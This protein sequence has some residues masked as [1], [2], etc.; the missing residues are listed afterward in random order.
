MSQL[1]MK[2]IFDTPKPAN[3]TA[4]QPNGGPQQPMPPAENLY[5]LGDELA[6]VRDLLRAGRSKEGE[7]YLT[8]ILDQYFPCW[9]V[10]SRKYGTG[11]DV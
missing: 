10:G 2:G 3:A 5:S 7:E 8:R 4:P 6:Q 11:M 1:A 9:R